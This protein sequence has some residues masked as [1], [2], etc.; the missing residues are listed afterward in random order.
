MTPELAA[1]LADMRL[2]QTE[3]LLEWL[4]ENHTTPATVSLALDAVTHARRHV[5]TLAAGD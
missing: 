2:L 3:R 5:K 1:A 4:A